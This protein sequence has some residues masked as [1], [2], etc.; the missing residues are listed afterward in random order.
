MPYGSVAFEI[1]DGSAH[2]VRKY[3]EVKFPTTVGAELHDQ[4]ISIAPIIP[5]LSRQGVVGLTIDRCITKLIKV[6][7]VSSYKQEN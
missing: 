6:T 4:I 2:C 1:L 5:T 3:I 7:V